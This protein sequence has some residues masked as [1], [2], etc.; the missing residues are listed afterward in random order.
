MDIET[1][2][3]EIREKLI[4]PTLPSDMLDENTKYLINPTGRFVLGGPA[5]DSGLT[6]PGTMRP[7]WPFLN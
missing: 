7:D 5:A 3:R 1:L 6:G 4:I 2:R